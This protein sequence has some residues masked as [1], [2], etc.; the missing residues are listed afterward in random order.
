MELGR[1]G[2]GRTPTIFRERSQPDRMSP[3]R[4]AMAVDEI[5]HRTN[6]ANTDNTDE[7]ISTTSDAR[8][9][10]DPDPERVARIVNGVT[11]LD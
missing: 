7:T 5:Q 11:Q 8:L 6:L 1:T 10:Y 3:G 9:A 4:G 2:A